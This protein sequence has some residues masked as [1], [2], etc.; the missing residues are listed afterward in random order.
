MAQSHSSEANSYSAVQEIF[1]MLWNPSVH[2]RDHNSSPL[3][4][5]LSQISH[6]HAPINLLKI[7]SLLPSQLCLVFPSGLS[8]R[9]KL[10]INKENIVTV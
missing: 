9:N 10:Y 5:I 8:P 4:P 6:I 2:Y 3:D 1:Q 7:L